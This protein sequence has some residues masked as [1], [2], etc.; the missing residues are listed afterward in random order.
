[1]TMIVTQNLV[2]I[3]FYSLVI[4]ATVIYIYFHDDLLVLNIYGG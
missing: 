3:H 4:V 2:Q 1:M